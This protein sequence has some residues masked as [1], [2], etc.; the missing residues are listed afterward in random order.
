MSRG[1]S[2]LLVSF[3]LSI[4]VLSIL[5][6]IFINIA[7]SM[8]SSSLGFRNIIRYSQL[9]EVVQ[10]VVN[11]SVDGVHLFNLGPSDAA[12]DQV[13]VLDPVNNVESREGLELC[14]SSVIPAYRAIACDPGYEYLAIITRDGAVIHIQTPARKAYPLKANATYIVPITFL[15]KNPE[16][17]Q[18]E[19]NV[20]HRLVAKPYTRERAN[21]RFAGVKSDKL[22]LLPPGQDEF[23]NAT[24]STDSSGLPFG[25]A[26]IGYDPS[27]IKV[28]MANPGS[29]A[30]P[31][32]TVMISGPGFSGEK[33]RI[34]G[35]EYTLSGNGSRILINNF[36]GVIQVRRGGS[37][38]ACSSSLP[39]QC[40][41]IS[42]PA[43]GSWYYGS[44]DSG[45]NLRI[46]LS[47]SASYVARFMRMSSGNSPTGETSYYPYLFVGDADGNGV[48]EVI[49]T[50]EDAYYGSSSATN[51]RYGNDDLSDYSTQPL[52]LKLL[53]IGKSLG[54][55]DGSID[56]RNFAG[57]ALYINIFFHDN[58]HPDE[59][60][61]SDNDRTDWVLRILLIGEDGSEYIVREYRY[62]EICN[63]HKTRITDFGRDNY[64]VKLSQSIYVPIP[65]GD[66]YW[67]AI[68]FQDPY[69]TG[70]TNDADITV[71][72]EFIGAIPF[73]R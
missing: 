57:V 66:R 45:I 73:S 28:K 65:S 51:D 69:A 35:R 27:W 62:Q 22:L 39:N 53:Q 17:L 44:T 55:P 58:S 34:G 54:S 49:F 37:V 32:F 29:D 46:Y 25:V 61:L 16:D 30:P 33:I 13:I 8:Q 42:L 20:S 38:I 63:Y 41:G 14:N 60:Q 23:F 6:Y 47:G 56:G 18:P 70:T 5:T 26:I 50:T 21:I 48:N 2:T 15:I 31:R 9:H 24:V 19:F 59:D 67:I 4:A 12:V 52:V 68:A 3:L 36:S 71:G 64:F 40:G 10:I 7:A 43:L 11:R 72:V 1:I